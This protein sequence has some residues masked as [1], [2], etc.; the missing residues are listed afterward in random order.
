LSHP[1]DKKYISPKYHTRVS[2]NHY[3][4]AATSFP[5]PFSFF[6]PINV[7]ALTSAFILAAPFGLPVVGLGASSF[8]AVVLA[9]LTAEELTLLAL[10]PSE[11]VGARFIAF[12]A[13][14]NFGLSFTLPSGVAGA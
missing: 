14:I 5:F 12:T 7:L 1:S 3:S 13:F 11:K 6:L 8:V 2:L 9:T 10:P 4:V